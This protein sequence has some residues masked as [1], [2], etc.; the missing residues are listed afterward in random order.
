VDVQCR[1]AFRSWIPRLSEATT[2]AP[3]STAVSGRDAGGRLARFWV[4]VPTQLPRKSREGS[5]RARG[6]WQL[7]R[8]SLAWPLN[9][10][11]GEQRA[12]ARRDLRR[13]ASFSLFPQVLIEDSAPSTNPR[14][15]S[16]GVRKRDHSFRLGCRRSNPSCSLGVGALFSVTVLQQAP[17]S[18]S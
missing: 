8:T 15:C 3:P 9:I 2:Q 13:G 6:M 4:P 10:H 7:H 16:S 12:I 14:G 1:K 11:P 5:L 18:T 17:T